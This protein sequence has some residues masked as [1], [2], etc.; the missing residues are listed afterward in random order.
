MYRAWR[1]IP[2]Q[3][4]P[5][6]IRRTQLLIRQRRVPAQLGDPGFAFFVV[7][8]VTRSKRSIAGIKTNGLITVGDVIDPGWRQLAVQRI[9][10]LHHMHLM[11]LGQPMQ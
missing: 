11:M 9:G 8:G 1:S 4:I 2:R 10:D 5:V 6:R 3:G 7:A